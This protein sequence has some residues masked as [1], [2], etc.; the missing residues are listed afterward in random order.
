MQKIVDGKEVLPSRLSRQ[1][2]RPPPV[3][4]GW[5]GPATVDGRC[6][7]WEV[8][9]A[10]NAVWSRLEPRGRG[11]C[12]MRQSGVLSFSPLSSSAARGSALP[13]PTEG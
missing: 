2:K 11:E 8:E 10:Q 12:V 1:E 3:L 7:I 6:L 5:A 9:H 4:M 13:L